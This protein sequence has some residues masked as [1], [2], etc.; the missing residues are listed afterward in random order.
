MKR[1]MSFWF[2][3]ISWASSAAL[4]LTC[5]GALLCVSA[6]DACA[7][8]LVEN[9]QAKAA[10]VIPAGQKSAAAE[11]LRHYVEKASGVRLAIVPENKLA[12]LPAGFDRVFVGPCRAADGVLD[13]QHLQPEG[14]VIKTVSDDLITNPSG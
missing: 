4:S 7:A 13:L 2:H 6:T 11:E 5:G 1:Q 12:A 14:F 10:I 9:G 3:T 8:T